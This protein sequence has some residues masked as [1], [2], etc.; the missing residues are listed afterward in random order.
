MTKLTSF[1]EQFAAVL[2]LAGMPI[3]FGFALAG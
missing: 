1:I 3:A 2:L